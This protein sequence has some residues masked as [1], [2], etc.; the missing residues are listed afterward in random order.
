MTNASVITQQLH[1]GW[2]FR[3]NNLMQWHPA[4]VPG[5]VHTDLMASGMIPDPFIA[6]N[7]RTVQWVDKEDWLYSTTFDLDSTVG[8]AD[9]VSQ[10]GRAHV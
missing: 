10:I 7:E 5:T 9:S 6:Q 4:T 1:S 3:Q 2:K 8:A